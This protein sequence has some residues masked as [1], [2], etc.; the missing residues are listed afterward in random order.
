[1]KHLKT[2]CQGQH[3]FEPITWSLTATMRTAH[4]FMC[5]SCLMIV[6]RTDIDKANESIDKCPPA[7]G[8]GRQMADIAFPV[9]ATVSTK[10]MKE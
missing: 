8:A 5:G 9:N 1:M 2:G 7:V 3:H 6:T 10:E 4:E